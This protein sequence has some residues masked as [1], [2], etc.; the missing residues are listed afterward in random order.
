MK[1]Y[2]RL[3]QLL[4]AR[5]NCIMSGNQEWQDRHEDAIDAIM[6]GAP[7]GSGFD[8]GTTLE[9]E[10]Y[11]GTLIFSTS[12]HHRND[13]GYYEGWTEHK[14]IVSPDLAHGYSL[15]VTGKNRNEIKAYIGE[16]FDDFLTE[17][18]TN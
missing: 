1:T 13:A 3:A 15:R 5:L 4:E 6:K 9:L 16:V 7:D 14:V 2:Q 17:L 11:N 8:A 18:T 12:Y 10:N